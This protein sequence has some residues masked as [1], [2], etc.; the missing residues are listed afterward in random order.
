[1]IADWARARARGEDV[2]MLASRRSQVD[3]LNRLARQ[4]MEAAGL[5]GQ[6]RLAIGGR[7]FAAGDDV[8]AGRNDYRIGL[9]NGTRG[10]VAAVDRTRRE[11]TVDTSEGRTITVPHHYLAA[12]HLTHGYATTVHKAQGATVD[13]GLLLI[14]DQT[15]REAAY[16]GLSRGRAANRVYSISDDP[17][18]IEAHGVAVNPVDELATLRQALAR[19]AAQQMAS[20][21][22]VLGR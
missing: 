15:Y 18:A 17:D 7:D 12:G 4:Q 22:P 16:T 9:L 5:L 10:T 19:T 20:R 14:D 2:L 3:A 11:V 21:S 13:I 8:I 6:N 1:M